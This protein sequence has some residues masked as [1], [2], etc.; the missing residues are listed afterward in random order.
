MLRGNIKFAQAGT[1]GGGY[2]LELCV[3]FVEDVQ[4][5]NW[6]VGSYWWGRGHWSRF[7]MRPT[8]S[9]AEGYE[10]WK[11]TPERAWAS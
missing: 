7:P 9:R 1:L 2:Q 4:Q 8:L 10:E 11:L 6:S 3:P 5:K